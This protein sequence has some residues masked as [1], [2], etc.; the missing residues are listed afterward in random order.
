VSGSSVGRLSKVEVAVEVNDATAWCDHALGSPSHLMSLYTS[1]LH[2]N[3]PVSLTTSTIC[4][5]KLVLLVGLPGQPLPSKLPVGSRSLSPKT[6][7]LYP[8]LYSQT[9][10]AVDASSFTLTTK[11]RESPTKTW[12]VGS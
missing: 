5:S 10:V 7:E 2:A 1:A 6:D 4:A 9:N 11:R 8:S 12:A 3:S